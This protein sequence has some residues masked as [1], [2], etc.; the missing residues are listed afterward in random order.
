[1]TVPC[2]VTKSS[3]ISVSSLPALATRDSV[4]IK[5]SGLPVLNVKESAAG[6]AM[7]IATLIVAMQPMIRPLLTTYHSAESRWRAKPN[8]G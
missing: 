3:A 2:V 8:L 5:P 1:M 6:I 7:R 4:A